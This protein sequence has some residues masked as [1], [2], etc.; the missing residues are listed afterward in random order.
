MSEGTKKR[1]NNNQQTQSKIRN[2]GRFK[3][4][5]S[6]QQYNFESSQ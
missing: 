5:Q 2:K 4:T 3:T 6:Q 1:A